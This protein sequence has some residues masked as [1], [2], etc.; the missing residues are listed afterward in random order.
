MCSVYVFLLL[1]LFVCTILSVLCLQVAAERGE[2]RRRPI[3]INSDGNGEP[4]GNGGCSKSSKCRRGYAS[5][6]DDDGGSGGGAS[7]G[8]DGYRCVVRQLCSGTVQP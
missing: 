2:A 6:S 4:N 3:I 7:S 8:Y 1:L 5:S